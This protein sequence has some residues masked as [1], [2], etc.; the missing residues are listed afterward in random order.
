[1]KNIDYENI[2]TR[3]NLFETNLNYQH[4][5]YNMVKHAL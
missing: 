2:K 1:M 3:L 5:D 4:V